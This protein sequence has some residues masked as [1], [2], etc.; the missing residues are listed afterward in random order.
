MRRARA[1][2]GPAGMSLGDRVLVGRL[3]E[4]DED[5]FRELVDLYGGR[6]YSLVLRLLG[7]PSEAE[8]V[9]Q[10]VFVTVWKSIETFRGEAK[11]STW[12]LRIAANQAKN[13]IK[14]LALR[15]PDPTEPDDL[16][17]GAVGGARS[18]LGNAPAAAPDTL[19]ERAELG[20]LLERAVARLDEEQRL[21]VILRDVEDLSYDE[22]C[23][24]TGLP[25]GTV[26]SRLHRARMALKDM[27]EGETKR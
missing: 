26:K 25:E 14:Y 21:L 27:L 11:L 5:A 10:E 23:E 12:L 17:E 19:F 16:S 7:N 9:A 2:V 3:L 24:V 1:R 8:D 22:I 18:S 15:A 20:N 4:R 13:R 6:I